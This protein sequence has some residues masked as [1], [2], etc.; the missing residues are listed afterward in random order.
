M[1]IRCPKCHKKAYTS[2]MHVEWICE[3]EELYRKCPTCGVL[4][5]NTTI[6]ALKVE[7]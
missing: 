2:T 6:E 4:I 1:L 5:Q 3:Y 7:E